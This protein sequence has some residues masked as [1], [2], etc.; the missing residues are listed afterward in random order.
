MDQGNAGAEKALEGAAVS[1]AEVDSDAP[2]ALDASAVR[3]SARPSGGASARPSLDAGDQPTNPPLVSLSVP[4]VPMLAQ[5]DLLEERHTD[6]PEFEARW[7][8]SPEPAVDDI[9]E[10]TTTDPPR[11]M[12]E[13]MTFSPGV[14]VDDMFEEART[15]PPVR[16]TDG[17]EAL[18]A[19]TA[20]EVAPEDAY[21]LEENYEPDD[22]PTPIFVK[23]LAVGDPVVTA[24]GMVV[25]KGSDEGMPVLI[26]G[27]RRN[28]TSEE[29]DRYASIFLHREITGLNPER[30]NASAT[31]LRRHFSGTVEDLLSLG[32]R[33]PQRVAIFVRIALLYKQF[34]EQ[35]IAVGPLAPEHIFLDEHLKPYILG[36]GIAPYHRAYTP[37]ETIRGQYVDPLSD[38]YTLGKILYYLTGKATPPIEKEDPPRLDRLMNMPAGLSRI[39]RRA[40]LRDPVL[41][42]TSVEAMLYDVQMYGRYKEVGLPHPDVK[43]RNKGGLSEPP[44]QWYGDDEDEGPTTVK[45]KIADITGITK[46]AEITGMHALSDITGLKKRKL[47]LVDRI[48]AKRRRRQAL[49]TMVLVAA[50]GIFGYQAVP[51]PNPLEPLAEADTT[52]VS[53]YLIELSISKTPPMLFGKVASD[54]Y[55]MSDAEQKAEAERILDEA[56]KR[57][58]I[59]DGFLHLN[60]GVVVQFW[61]GHV[62]TFPQGAP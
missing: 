53:E 60:D 12:D 22:T 27:L 34:H 4:A 62:I 55:E 43:E 26:V 20:V 37:P 3:P 35:G 47:T 29:K 18:A 36:P 41:R 45:E 11:A 31:V 13:R 2:D 15:D 57:W 5:D 59:P 9:F 28:A 1:D 58:K 10:E 44:P 39:I 21:A 52:D 40:T 19:R 7:T 16:P 51:A 17:L 6:P 30:A 14:A 32:E 8:Y 48:E 56:R 50:V 42:Y 46:L 33:L 49:M 23:D 25:Y 24:P 54:W 38:V 61:A